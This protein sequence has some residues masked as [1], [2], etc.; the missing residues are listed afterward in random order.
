MG[1]S[2]VLVLDVIS[3]NFLLIFSQRF[4]QSKSNA[5]IIETLTRLKQHMKLL[6]HMPPEMMVSD[7][8]CAICNVVLAVFPQVDLIQD[9]WH[10]IA[11]YVILFP[12][13]V[14]LLNTHADSANL[15][16]IF[17]YDHECE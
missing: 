16:Q 8:C 9:V 10:F 14:S 17:G 15:T 5:E 1:K 7:N 3:T 13:A 12:C 2:V 6:G 4:C 11:Q